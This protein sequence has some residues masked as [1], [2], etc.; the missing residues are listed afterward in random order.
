MEVNVIVTV[1]TM[2]LSVL[3][4]FTP[5]PIDGYGLSWLP[6]GRYS[7]IMHVDLDAMKKE[8]AWKVYSKHCDYEKKYEG[9]ME[10]P[11]SFGDY[12]KMT[13]ATLIKYSIDREWVG[14]LEGNA[15]TSL[16]SQMSTLL[17]FQYDYLGDLI[18]ESLAKGEIGETGEMYLDRKIYSYSRR[19]DSKAGGTLYGTASG[20]GEWLVA[21]KIE[22]VKLML[23][24]GYGSHQNILMND[25]MDEVMELV[26]D[27]GHWWRLRMLGEERTIKLEALRQ[28][29]SNKERVEYMEEA[30]KEYPVYIAR[31]TML[32]QRDI[33]EK[34]IFVFGDEK[35]ARSM[36]DALVTSYEGQGEAEKRSNEYKR[37]KSVETIEGN[38][39]IITYVLDEELMRLENEAAKE[40]EE[41][42]KKEQEEE[43]KDEAKEPRAA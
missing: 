6:T 17:V 5:N 25:N 22:L 1:L 37:Q 35:Y 31:A 27:L 34:Q 30:F 18:D 38:K 41:M 24:C 19:V 15:I 36:K 9:Y 12:N 2:M 13:K 26:E 10:L 21:E 23:A 39:V 8:E 16:N 28:H 7:S 11:K 42:K 20:T 33:I 29:D 43:A 3:Y 14:S 32:K 40:W 4:G